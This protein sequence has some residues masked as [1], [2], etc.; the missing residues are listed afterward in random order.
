MLRGIYSG[1]FS[2]S[3]KFCLSTL[4]SAFAGFGFLVLALP[5][6][7]GAQTAHFVGVT[8]T[9][10]GSYG[11]LR[12]VALDSNGNVFVAD[13]GNNAVYEILAAGG[14]TT[15][16]TLGGG[17][18]GPMGIAVD[19]N[20][21]VFVTDGTAVKEILAEGGYT[22]VKTLGSG[23]NYPIGVA[24]DGSGNVFVADTYNSA[25][26]EILA[27]GG[28]ATVKTLFTDNPLML[29]YG[30][31]LDANGNLYSLN[32]TEGW[33]SSF[34]R[35][36]A[37]PRSSNWAAYTRPRVLHWTRME[38]FSQQA[39]LGCKSFWRRVATPRSIA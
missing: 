14:Y 21:N 12:G 22:T 16:T 2:I 23:F 29:T 1:L 13:G 31:A 5:V 7:A 28:Y 25:I 39:T 33:S 3:L 38:T 11:Y 9:L 35:L 4:L 20:D 34:W 17:F 26:K 36:A 30:V 18:T 6:S 27:I 24:V 15:V 19:G 32:I 10:G 37:T 8:Q